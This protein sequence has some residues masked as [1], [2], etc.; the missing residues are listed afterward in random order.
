M[1]GI[2]GFKGE[3]SSGHLNVMKQFLFHRGPDDSGEYFNPK[4]QIGLMH[5]RLSIIDIAAGHQ[6]LQNSDGS[7]QVIFNGHTELRREL[8]LKWIPN[9]S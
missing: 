8:K 7:I 2:A 5:T 4:S 9:S 1:C 3:W 6:P